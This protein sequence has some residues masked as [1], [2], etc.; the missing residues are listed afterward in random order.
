MPNFKLFLEW[1]EGPPTPRWACSHE[2]GAFFWMSMVASWAQSVSV[3]TSWAWAQSLQEH[4]Q[5]TYKCGGAGD[6]ADLN[7][8]QSTL[9]VLLPNLKMSVVAYPMCHEGYIIWYWNKI[10]PPPL[11]LGL[12]SGVFFTMYEY[13]IIFPPLD[14]FF[15]LWM[16]YNIQYNF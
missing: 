1:A 4:E 9:L 2:H 10:V 6:D 12:I 7:L 15:K 14:I 3:K 13:I 11:L 8:G 16:F 5:G